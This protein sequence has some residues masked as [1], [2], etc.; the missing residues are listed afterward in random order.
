MATADVAR[1][2]DVLRRA[3]GDRQLTYVGYSYGSFLGVTYANLFPD[4][5]RAIGGRRRDGP[6][7]LD[8]G[9]R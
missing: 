1:D 2:L 9:P 5:V 4:S 8:H 6:D 7:R 3:V